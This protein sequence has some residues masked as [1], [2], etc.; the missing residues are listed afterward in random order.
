MDEIASII[1]L[2]LKN[3]EDPAKLKE[4]EERV[5]ALSGKYE[6]YPAL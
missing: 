3:P 1:G 6:L 4:A 5:A 2:V